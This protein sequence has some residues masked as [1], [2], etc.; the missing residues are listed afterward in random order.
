M[1]KLF[2]E[3]SASDGDYNNW[4]QQTIVFWQWSMSDWEKMQ[5]CKMTARMSKW[6]KEQ[7]LQDDQLNSR[8]C[9]FL[10]TV[11]W[12][13]V[14]PCVNVRIRTRHPSRME[15]S[16]NNA[17]GTSCIAWCQNFPRTL[18]DYIVA[19]IVAIFNLSNHEDSPFAVQFVS[20]LSCCH[21]ALCTK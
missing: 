7:I 6:E 18:L 5:F 2:H 1:L 3:G 21:Y 10:T 20:S 12:C 15:R 16:F 4:Q 9:F 8:Y 19:I 17:V 13:V 14:L 11:S